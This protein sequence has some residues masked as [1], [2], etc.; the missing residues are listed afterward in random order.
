[1]IDIASLVT[2]CQTVLAGGSKFIEGYKRK[3]LSK[4]ER[5][6]MIAAA[7][8]GTFHLLSVDQIPGTWVRAGDKDFLDAATSDHAIAAKYL[9][10]FRNLCERGYIVH[11][12]GHLFML[13]GSGFEKARNL[14]V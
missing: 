12:G 13:T 6:L 2:L 7:Q 8:K 11:E 10:A 3:R 9:E 14:A 1:M 5:E 4:E